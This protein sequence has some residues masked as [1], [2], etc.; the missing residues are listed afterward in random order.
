M[1]LANVRSSEPRRRF[2]K[3]IRWQ[4][5]SWLWNHKVDLKNWH[6]MA[7][8]WNKSPEIGPWRETWVHTQRPLPGSTHTCKGAVHRGPREWESP[9]IGGEAR[10]HFIFQFGPNM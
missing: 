1:L 9:L 6:L 7:Y 10:P 5:L 8:N 3:S 2:P 4:A